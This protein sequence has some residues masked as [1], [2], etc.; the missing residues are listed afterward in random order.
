MRHG[1]AT[2]SS[3][4]AAGENGKK[5]PGPRGRPRGPGA[6][7]QE[8]LETAGVNDRVGLGVLA[9]SPLEVVLGAEDVIALGLPGDPALEF[10][11]IQLPNRALFGVR[12]A[13]VA[14]TGGADVVQRL[15]RGRE[16]E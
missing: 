13:D 11:G 12:E 15:L 3:L 2:G 16:G 9:D 10:R 14:K 8:S 7:L 4:R 5:H 6:C 1:L